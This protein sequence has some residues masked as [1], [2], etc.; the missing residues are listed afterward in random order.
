LLRTAIEGQVPPA[1]ALPHAPAIKATPKMA[2]APNASM[3]RFQVRRVGMTGSYQ[4]PAT[5][6][7]RRLRASGCSL[8]AYSRMSDLLATLRSRNL[9]QDVTA[10]LETRLAAGPITGYV[11]FDPTAES[12]HVGNLVPVMALAWLQRLGGRPLV[13]VGGGTGMVG[14]PSGKR[15]E[16]PM[17]SLEQLEKNVYALREQLGRF[18]DYTGPQAAKLLNNAEWLGRTSLLGFLRDTGKH[19]TIGYMLQKE[20]VKSRLETG[21]SFTE[22]AYMLVQ[23]HDYEH[24]F[25][26]EGCELQMGGSDQWGNIT[27]GVELVGKKHGKEVHGLTLPLLTTASGAKFG[28]SEGGNIWLDPERTSPYAFY[29]FWIN[30]DDRDAERLLLTFSFLAP[31]AIAEVMVAHRAAPEKRA[32]Q[33]LLAAEM[34]A[35]IHGADALAKA[36][37]AAAALFSG[38]AADAESLRSLEMPEVLI[39]AAEFGEGMPIVEVLVRAKLASSKADARRGIDGRGFYLGGDAIT[40]AS[41]R[42]ERGMLEKVDG[43]LVAILRK[44]KRNYVRFVIKPSE[45]LKA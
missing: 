43:S 45:G 3:T 14:D 26:T 33:R 15:S 28:K 38:G 17:L 9:V 27:A 40:D 10:G 20:S 4:R 41:A 39:D 21:I 35:R 34:T 23:A 22:F 37:S 36:E 32:A 16:R 19:F 8:L 42:L 1:H 11:G 5:S 13:I 29:Q 18:V 30:Q 24:L 25:R 12:L 6:G 31:D 2:I 7:Q 44:G